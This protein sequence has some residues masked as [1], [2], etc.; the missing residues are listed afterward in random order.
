VAAGVLLISQALECDS[1]EDFHILEPDIEVGK[2]CTWQAVEGATF[3]PEYAQGTP[4][5]AGS[6]ATAKVHCE[7]LGVECAGITL[8]PCRWNSVVLYSLR[9]Q[10]HPHISPQGETSW[11]KRCVSE[12][13]NVEDEVEELS[14]PSC[15]EEP[16]S[17]L[18]LATQE[19]YASGVVNVNLLMHM[20]T[21]LRMAASA[22]GWQHVAVACAPA[23][24]QT[25]LLR[26][27]ERMFVDAEEQKNLEDIYLEILH[28]T[29]AGNASFSLTPRVDVFN[30]LSQ[31]PLQQGF[32]RLRRLREV[33]K[34]QMAES[35]DFVLCFCSVAKSPGGG[36]PVVEAE[37]SSYQRMFISYA[38]ILFM[39]RCFL[40]LKYQPRLAII[41]STLQVRLFRVKWCKVL[42]SLSS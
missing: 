1:G 30:Q 32:Q 40:S 24:L 18:R 25:L 6:L 36:Y 11:L 27:E 15:D 41:T 38:H 14:L 3:L 29:I 33:G 5:A 26:Q 10:A 2:E 13:L 9:A 7:A 16:F 12:E 23:V 17:A 39:A 19:F 35:V 28:E 37:F 34:D 4:L 22:G 21:V 42:N 8:Q 31:W 20:G